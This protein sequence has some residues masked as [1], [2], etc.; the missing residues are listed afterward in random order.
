MK[1]ASVANFAKMSTL[2]AAMLIASRHQTLRPMHAEAGNCASCT[3]QTVCNG[4]L[5]KGVEGCYVVNDI[6]HPMGGSCGGGS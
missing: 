3:T 1:S 2:A 4:G 6:C 5:A